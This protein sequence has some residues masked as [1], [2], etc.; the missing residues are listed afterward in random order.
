MD[1]KYNVLYDKMKEEKYHTGQHAEIDGF[2]DYFT[3][4]IHYLQKI[5]TELTS[6]ESD[7]SIK[8]RVYY[9]AGWRE[10]DRRGAVLFIHGGGW[11]RDNFDQFNI[12]S[13]YFALR[14]MVAITATHHLLK[15]DNVT[16]DMCIRD[17]AELVKWVRRNAGKLG[18]DVNRIALCGGSSGAQLALSTALFSD[19]VL[20]QPNVLV[21]FNPAINIDS[22]S[23]GYAFPTEKSI[24][25][26]N[27]IS[28]LK[29]GLPDKVE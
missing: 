12:H 22:P 29:E 26:Y 2:I 5:R 24:A 4:N 20:Q 28:H 25:R 6:Y 17:A 3:A 19:A 21:L 18:I 9:P 11:Q 16:V 23:F 27:T 8:A 7:G 13:R 1:L 10:S 15:D 14:G